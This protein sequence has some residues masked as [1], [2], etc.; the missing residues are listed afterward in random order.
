[1]VVGEQE[2][3]RR[4]GEEKREQGGQ[5][6]PWLKCH[7]HTGKRAGGREGSPWPGVVDGVVRNASQDDSVAGTC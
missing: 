2:R 3:Q 4:Q 7:G 5:E 1:M 6:S